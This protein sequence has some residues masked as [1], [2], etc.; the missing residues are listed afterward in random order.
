MISSRVASGDGAARVAS[1]SSPSAVRSGAFGLEQEL[2]AGLAVARLPE[3]L[4][5]GL[6]RARCGLRA[7][8][9]AH[10]DR[11]VIVRARDLELDHLGAE[12]V[13]VPVQAHL[14]VEAHAELV[15]PLA[16]VRRG[17]DPQRVEVVDDVAVVAVLRQVADREVHGWL[18]QHSTLQVDR[19]RGRHREVALVDVAIDQLELVLYPARARQ[20]SARRRARAAGARG[21]R[22]G[23]RAAGRAATS[24]AARRRSRAP[25]QRL[26]ATRPPIRGTRCRRAGSGHR[27]DGRSLP[28]GAPVGLETADRVQQRERLALAPRLLAASGGTETR[29]IRSTMSAAS[30]WAPA[31]RNECP[32]SRSIVRS[33]SPQNS[34]QR[35]LTS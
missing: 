28:D 31:S 22:S 4:P 13:G 21:R 2:A 19:R 35:S 26:D 9:R 11:Q 30:I 3:R 6:G 17:L 20:R 16:A 32:S 15:A 27:P 14:G 29:S 12:V 18:A 24:A 34:A 25:A 33:S 10:V 1:R 23:A 8:A 7:H 5:R